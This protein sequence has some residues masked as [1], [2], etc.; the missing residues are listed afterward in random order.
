VD[1]QDLKQAL[2]TTFDD[3]ELSQS[4]RYELRDILQDLHFDTEKLAFLRNR[5]LDIV[6]EE[7]PGSKEHKVLKWLGEVIKLLDGARTPNVRPIS[8]AFFSPGEDCL[9]EIR[10][11]LIGAKKTLDICVFTLTDDRL[12]RA[13][14][15]VAAKGCKVRLISDNLKRFDAGS[16]T[17]Q[18]AR[19]GIDVVYDRAEDHM[20]HKFA[21]VDGTILING[22]FNWTRSASRGNYEN[23]T[24][25]NDIQLLQRFKA[26]FERLWRLFKSLE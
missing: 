6:R 4:E 1:Q 24:V 11:Q 13:V 14:E 20:H 3:L 10:I 26:E 19:N 5:A 7:L 21:I 2:L 15:A 23:I 9:E 17:E 18:L 25:T 12:T 16:D 8:K 22:S